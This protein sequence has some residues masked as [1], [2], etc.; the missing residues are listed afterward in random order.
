MIYGNLSTGVNRFLEQEGTA[1]YAGLDVSADGNTVA[2]GG[3]QHVFVATD[4]AQHGFTQM[5]NQAIGETFV[6]YVVPNT[7]TE[8]AAGTNLAVFFSTDRGLDW[9]AANYMPNIGTITG[10]TSTPD[11][12]EIYIVSG[13]LSINQ[14]LSFVKIQL[15]TETT[16]A[17]NLPQIPINC[18]ARAKDG[19]LFLGTDY[20]VLTSTDDGVT[21]NPIGIGLPPVQVLSLQVRGSND[22]YLLA[23]TYGRGTWVYQRSGSGVAAA[24]DGPT[25]TLAPPIPSEINAN[26][27]ATVSFNFEKGRNYSM[28]LYNTNGQLIRTLDAGFKP[29]GSYHATISTAELSAG[30]Y[31]VALSSEGQ[32]L[33]QKLLVQ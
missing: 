8:I 28:A 6:L 21:W 29:A 11:G 1:F 20:D 26:S 14:N 4:G 33:N 7:P 24:A 22:Q 9:G 31:F 13:G 16:P 5:S 25:F 23:G 12:S 17:T 32:M 18:I 3:K 27:S 19:T 15:R 2:E 30:M 10:I